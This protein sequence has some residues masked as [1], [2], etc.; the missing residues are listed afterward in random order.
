MFSA[1]SLAT[2][3]RWAGYVLM[4]L[5]CVH[6]IF[7]RYFN[8]RKELARLSPI[9][10]EMMQVHT[11]F[12]ALTVFGI[13]LL[14]AVQTDDLIGTPLGRW[15]SRGLAVFWGLRLYVQ[16]FGYSRE[17]WRGKWFETR[18]HVVFTLLWMWLTGLFGWAGW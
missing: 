3:L 14:C 11:L 18:V 15:L 16:W 17:L 10:R 8:W 13:G 9:N 4:V 7:P 1:D 6:V 5:A 12:I 2:Q